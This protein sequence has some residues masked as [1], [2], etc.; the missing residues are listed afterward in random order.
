MH[1]N[2]Y[3]PITYNDLPLPLTSK[4]LPGL[5]QGGTADEAWVDKPM[6]LQYRPDQVPFDA[7]LTLFDWAQ[8]YGTGV[9]ELRYGFPDAALDDNDTAA[10][11]E[12]ARW[13]HRRWSAGDEV[14]IRCQAGLN[15][16]GLLTALVLM[17]EGWEAAAA[18][19]HIRGRRSPNALFNNSFV[20]WLLSDAGRTVGAQ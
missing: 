6:A 3:A 18:I 4:I 11:L 15:R 12:A 20:D 16:S 10:I 1:H 17:L 14:L 7:V 2:L 19:R 13:A 8:P 5:W 9:T